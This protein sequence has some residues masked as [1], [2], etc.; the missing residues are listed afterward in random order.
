MVITLPFVLFLL[1]YWPLSRIQGAPAGEL[2]TKTAIPQRS[3]RKVL[4]EKLPLLALSAASAWI[5]MRAQRL[6]GAV[7][8][9]DQFPFGVRLENSIVAYATY[10][11]KMIWPAKLAVLYPHPGNSLPAWRIVLGVAVLLAV[12]AVVIKYR[13]R[14][15]LVTGWLWFLGTLVPVI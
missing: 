10:L 14:R 2:G 11:W 9:E 5:T 15:Y 13:S 1:D 8:S 4:I 6:G 7:R 3:V 12:S